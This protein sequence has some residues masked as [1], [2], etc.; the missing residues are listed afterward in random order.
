MALAVRPYVTAW[1]VVSACV[2]LVVFQR[3]RRNGRAFLLEAPSEPPRAAAAEPQLA[4]APPPPQLAS[5]AAAAA[6]AGSRRPAVRSAEKDRAATCQFADDLARCSIAAHESLCK[7]SGVRYE[8]VFL[9]LT[10]SS[11][12]SNPILP[13]YHTGITFLVAVQTV[14]S[15]IVACTTEAESGR[16]CELEVVSLGVGTKFMRM[17]AIARDING[18]CVRDSHAE[19]LARRGFQRYLLS[20]LRQCVR[21]STS[22]FTAPETQGGLFSLRR[23]IFFFSLHPHFSHMSH[24]PF[25]HI[26]EF[27]STSFILGLSFHLYSSSQPCGNASIKRWAKA[28]AGPPLPS[29]QLL[30]AEEHQWME[31]PKHARA[32]GMVALS[33]KREPRVESCTLAEGAPTAT[34]EEVSSHPASNPPALC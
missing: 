13:I 1:I 21:G 30:P 31:M 15:A 20:Q 17:A 16:V 2:V 10:H 5:E 11:H 25:S 6:A 7:L 22:I 9:S 18:A 26:P 32:Q 23:G 4:C 33:V 28:G 29:S 19:V 24:T 8:Q 34:G 14:A 27:N 12:M 3:R